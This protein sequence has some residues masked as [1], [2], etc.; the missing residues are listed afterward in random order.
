MTSME[1]TIVYTTCWAR[2]ENQLRREP[3]SNTAARAARFVEMS[4]RDRRV[5]NYIRNEP[6][7]PCIIL[8]EVDVFYR[9]GDATVAVRRLNR[10][11]SLEE[12]EVVEASDLYYPAQFQTVELSENEDRWDTVDDATAEKTSGL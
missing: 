12:M 3:L 2:Q 9:C 1:R 6:G 10:D 8:H 4:S 5:V 11:H 7:Q